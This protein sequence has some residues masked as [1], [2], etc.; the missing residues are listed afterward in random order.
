VIA[1]SSFGIAGGG[2]ATIAALV[3]LPIMGLPVQIAALLISVGPL[4]DMARTT[5]VVAM[6]S[7]RPE[8]Y[9]LP[10]TRPKVPLSSGKIQPTCH[11]VLP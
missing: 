8:P 6:R 3:V 1:I 11:K 2:G 4:I 9:L 10:L 5:V 7:H